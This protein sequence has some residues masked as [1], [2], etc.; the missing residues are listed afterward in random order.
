MATVSQSPDSVKVKSSVLPT[1]TGLAVTVHI[2]IL[3]A[4]LSSLDTSISVIDILHSR[5]EEY[6]CLVSEPFL[7][8]VMVLT[9][10]VNE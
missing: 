1:Q 5:S 2:L 3:S 4:G 7:Y 10:M 6:E 9:L 8:S